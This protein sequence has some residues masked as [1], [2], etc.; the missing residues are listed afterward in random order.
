MRNRSAVAKIKLDGY[1]CERC[2]HI[3]L[4]RIYGEAEGQGDPVICPKCKSPYWNKPKK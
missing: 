2:G 3:W 1:R 4:P